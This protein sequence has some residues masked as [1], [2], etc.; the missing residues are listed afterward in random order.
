M[1]RQN[2]LLSKAQKKFKGI[3]GP[4]E[5]ECETRLIRSDTCNKLEARQV[6]FFTIFIMI[7][8]HDRSI[9][10]FTVA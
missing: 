2:A 7:K 9:K 3:V 5:L 10:P 8:S 4:F 1:T 6:F